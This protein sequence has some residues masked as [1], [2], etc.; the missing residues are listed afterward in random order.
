M[1]YIH[2]LRSKIGHRKT[3]IV[4]GVIVLRDEAGGVL[5]QRRTDFDIWGLPGGIIEP[6]ENILECTRRELLEESGLL[7]GSLH[8]V[9][10]YTDP[11]YDSVYPNGD[12]VQQYSVVFQG[13][14][15]GGEM[16]V[17]GEETSALAFFPPNEIPFA[18]LP[19]FYADMIRDALRGGPPVF[20]PPFS[21]PD[22]VDQIAMIRPLL[23]PEL[24]L[25]AGAIVAARDEQGRLLVV[26]RTDD[27]EWSLPGGYTNLGE[28][29]AYTAQR[30]VLEETGCQVALERILGVYSPS[31][32]WAYPNGDQTQAVITVFRARL[33]GGA[34]RPDRTETSQVGWMT[35]DELLQLETHPILRQ[36]NQA[37]V[38]NLEQGV[39]V[40]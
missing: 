14:L 9:G 19:N 7:C 11:Q 26:K 34:P 31:S 6:G 4:Y 32:P 29:V 20:S 24:Y 8:L 37:V 36:L 10:V 30:E 28:N 39:F 38:E 22:P 15:A 17:D 35:C 12:Q 25:G 5:L 23:G 40:I 33:A 1:S 18:E 13:P 3:I 2:W 16:Q 27:G 21:L